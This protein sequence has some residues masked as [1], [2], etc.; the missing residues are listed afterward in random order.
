MSL[1][2]P[3]LYQSQME[4]NQC[5]VTFFIKHVKLNSSS[6]NNATMTQGQIKILSGFSP[7]LSTTWLFSN[8]L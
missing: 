3:C 2:V 4:N 1:K 5:M 7:K 6:I 8:E